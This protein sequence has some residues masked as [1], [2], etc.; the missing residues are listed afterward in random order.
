MGASRNNMKNINSNDAPQGSVITNNPSG[1]LRTVPLFDTHCHLNFKAYKKTLDEVIAQ[2]ASEGVDHI[3]IP[4]TDVPT[5]QR[6]VEI[7]QQYENFYAAVGI[8]PHHV[9][10]LYAKLEDDTHSADRIIAEQVQQIEQLLTKEKVVAVGEIGIDRHLYIATKYKEYTVT[11]E[12]VTVQKQAF[13]AQLALVV[14]YDKSL[15]IHNREARSTMLE[16]LD[17]QWSSSLQGRTVFHCCEADDALLEFAKHH[18]IYIGVD[19]DITYGPEKG[20][21]NFIQKVPHHMLVLETDSPFLL[22]EPLR[23]QKQYPNK[24]GNLRIIAQAVA[25]AWQIRVEDVI[26][27]TTQ[28]AKKLFQIK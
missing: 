14:K 4:G 10:E 25:E 16:L 26:D 6:A 23:T 22:P 13:L 1:Y 8:H 24:P 11:D 27:I 15:I 21:A 7:A 5:S 20:K 28:N 17:Q 18:D 3:V 19:G 2:A 9:F 12:F